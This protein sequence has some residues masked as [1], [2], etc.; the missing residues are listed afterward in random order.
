[1]HTMKRPVLKKPDNI[2]HTIVYLKHTIYNNHT[3]NLHLLK[4]S[5]SK[6]ITDY[7]ISSSTLSQNP[8]FPRNKMVT[9]GRIKK[10]FG[11]LLREFEQQIPPCSMCL[12]YAYYIYWLY[13]NNTQLYKFK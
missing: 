11:P 13:R 10:S 7:L 12:F 2:K 5:T 1:M 4:I 6:T 8:P 3:S 9:D